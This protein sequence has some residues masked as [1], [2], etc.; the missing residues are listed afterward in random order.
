MTRVDRDALL[1]YEITSRQNLRLVLERKRISLP[2]LRKLLEGLEQA[3]AV[4]EE[5]LL[6]A[7]RILLQP[8]YLYLDPDTWKIWICFYPFET[9]ESGGGL[10]GLAEY[11]LDHLERQDSRAV[12]L[13]YEFYRMAGEENPSVRKL[14]EEWG[15]G[16]A[17][18]EAEEQRENQGAEEQEKRKQE[19]HYGETAKQGGG[20]TVY[21]RENQ[22]GS[23]LAEH[24]P[25]WVDSTSG[26]TA[27]LAGL[28]EPGLFL[29]SE[30]AAYPDLRIQKESF[31]IGKKKDAVDGW[32]KARG[33]SRIHARIS[34]EEDC[35]YLTDLNSTNGTFLN[36]GRLGVNEKARLRPGDSVGFADVRYVVEG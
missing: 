19:A 22:P 31:L 9:Q 27:C 30:S 23:R 12:T 1:Y 14:L 7:E 3:A 20:E 33:I 15:E 17:E 6:D 28:R 16:A 13:G 29:R 10:L 34:R 35:Y 32:L 26:G 8:E 2:E 11:L 18:K 25:E 5:Y 4:C 21:C 24:F 36:G